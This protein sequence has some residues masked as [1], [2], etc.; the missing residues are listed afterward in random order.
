M[1][2]NNV[3]LSS[4]LH[5]VLLPSVPCLY[6]VLQHITTVTESTDIGGLLLYCH[7]I[8]PREP[9]NEGKYSQRKSL[10][11]WIGEQCRTAGGG[12]TI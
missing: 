7:A 9:P 11:T 1:V 12:F 6:H 4:S 10:Q 5:L 8:T 3:L 2:A